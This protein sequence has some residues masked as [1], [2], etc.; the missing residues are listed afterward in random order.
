MYVRLLAQ[1]AKKHSN[2]ESIWILLF[3]AMVDTVHK[4]KKH[5]AKIAS[6]SQGLQT[7]SFK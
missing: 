3:P 1:H 2:C 7:H 5:C 6:P 4:E